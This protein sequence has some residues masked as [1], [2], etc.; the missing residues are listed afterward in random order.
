MLLEQQR[1]NNNANEQREYKI[2]GAMSEE[3]TRGLANNKSKLQANSIPYLF[4]RHYSND[5]HR[6]LL[7]HTRLFAETGTLANCQV[8]ASS[9]KLDQSWVVIGGKDS[10]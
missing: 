8:E 7:Y 6:V 3:D 4:W 5:T 2:Q 10:R 1:R 9:K